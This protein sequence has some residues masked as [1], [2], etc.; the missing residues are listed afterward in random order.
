VFLFI[1]EKGL[2]YFTRRIV[3]VWRMGGVRVGPDARAQ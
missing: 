2:K 3:W 1:H